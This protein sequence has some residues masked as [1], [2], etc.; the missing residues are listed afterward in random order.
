MAWP[1]GASGS[2]LAVAAA[3]HGVRSVKTCKAV[4]PALLSAACASVSCVVLLTAA[5]PGRAGRMPLL[6]QLQPTSAG[7][8]PLQVWLPS[9]E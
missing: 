4:A 6:F 5:Q 3:V 9:Q 1:W 8:L 7:N 2:S